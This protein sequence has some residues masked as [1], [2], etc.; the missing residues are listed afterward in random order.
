MHLFDRKIL[1]LIIAV[2]RLNFLFS[3]PIPL[4]KCKNI[5]NFNKDNNSCNKQYIVSG[6]AKRS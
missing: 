1:M 4:G 2:Q 3:S 6:L 5:Y